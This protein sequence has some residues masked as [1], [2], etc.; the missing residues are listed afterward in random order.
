MTTLEPR[1]V[2]SDRER[3]SPPLRGF[4]FRL[5]A[6]WATGNSRGR[7]SAAE[8]PSLSK[9]SSLGIAD[10]RRSAYRIAGIVQIHS[11]NVKESFAS[12]FVPTSKCLQTCFP[13]L[14]RYA[15]PVLNRESARR[16]PLASSSRDRDSPAVIRDAADTSTAASRIASTDS[17]SSSVDFVRRSIPALACSLAAACSSADAAMLRILSAVRAK[18]PDSPAS[19]FPCRLRPIRDPASP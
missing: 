15:S 16:R 4:P 14:K 10:H 19:Q 1:D 17:V 11:E 18:S 9:S 8:R 13:R 5:T 7:L 2:G 12:F 3:T 6:L